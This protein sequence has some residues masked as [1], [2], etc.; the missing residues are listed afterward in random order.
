MVV[1]AVLAGAMMLAAIGVGELAGNDSGG[2][3]VG[4]APGASGGQSLGDDEDRPNPTSSLE[5]SPTPSTV[6]LS[7]LGDSVMLAAENQIKE[8][9]PSAQVDAAVGRTVPEALEILRRWAARDEIGDVVLI[10]IGNNGDFTEAEFEEVVELV[11]D[12]RKLVFV[13]LTVPTPW[14]APNN[15]MIADGVA[16]H[17]GLTLVDWHSATLS[18]DGLLYEDGAHLRPEGAEYYAELVSPLLSP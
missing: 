3:M 11:G 16:R 17:D 2:A 13:N 5:P 14:E 1:I 18:R 9:F 4:F 12:D 15:L 7:A 8:R 6:E 10:H